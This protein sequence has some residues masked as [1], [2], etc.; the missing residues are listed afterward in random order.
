MVCSN[1]KKLPKDH[2]EVT[3]VAPKVSYTHDR[4]FGRYKAWPPGKKER[5][6]G[7]GWCP[8]RGKEY[9]T[10]LKGGESLHAGPSETTGL[11]GLWVALGAS[12]RV[13]T[14]R[15]ASILPTHPSHEIM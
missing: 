4:D 1:E 7:R 10:W 14:S 5:F 15:E 2:A 13:I 6:M 12:W 8:P 3:P 9:V 11:V